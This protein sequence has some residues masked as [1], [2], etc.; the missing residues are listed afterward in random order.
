M[1]RPVRGHERGVGGIRRVA[2]VETADHDRVVLHFAVGGDVACIDPGSCLLG[3]FG[4][5]NVGE[6]ATRSITVLVDPDYVL[7]NGG[8]APTANAGFAVQVDYDGGAHTEPG[9]EQSAVMILLK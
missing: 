2:E 6:T 1:A 7:D 3:S 4:L 8:G 5:I 9:W